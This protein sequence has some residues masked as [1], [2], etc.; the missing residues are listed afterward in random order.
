LRRTTFTIVVPAV[1]LLALVF[2]ILTAPAEAAGSGYK[3]SGTDPDD[4]STSNPDIRGTTEKVWEGGGGHRWYTLTIRA[5]EPLGSQWAVATYLD[6]SGGPHWDVNINFV[7]GEGGPYCAL[8]WRAGG[9]DIVGSEQE[10][11]RAT[12]VFPLVELRTDKHIRWRVRSADEHEAA[13][14][15][16]RAPDA[17]FY[18]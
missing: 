12:C 17:G 6:T 1:A 4:I 7:N 18:P 13:R 8:N 10:G 9:G 14:S 16:D 2:V 15:I 11:H 5:Y 3:R